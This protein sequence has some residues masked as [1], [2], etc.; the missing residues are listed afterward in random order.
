MIKKIVYHGKDWF[1]DGMSTF[2]PC[3]MH[4]IRENA[5]NNINNILDNL[6]SPDDLTEDQMYELYINN[7]VING[8]PYYRYI[9]Y[10]EDS[11]TI[12]T[13]SG[14]T[15]DHHEFTKQVDEYENYIKL[16]N[17]S[18]KIDNNEA[19]II[20]DKDDVC[21]YLN[22]NKSNGVE[23]C[24]V[25]YSDIYNLGWKEQISKYTTKSELEEILSEIIPYGEFE[26]FEESKLNLLTNYEDVEVFIQNSKSKERSI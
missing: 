19:I 8:D 16:D 22:N 1:V 21:V 17:L 4:E 20:Y 7:C 24:K 3:D 15:S 23:L 12:F 9:D 13:L 26:T 11:D 14:Q 25:Y 6:N 5:L 18:K 10:D 2:E